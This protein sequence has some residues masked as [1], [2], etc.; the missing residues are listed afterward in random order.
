MTRIG[1]TRSR[2]SGKHYL[3]TINSSFEVHYIFGKFD[4]RGGLIIS[5]LDTG[6]SGPGFDPWDVDVLS[7]WT[8]HLASRNVF[9]QEYKW[10]PDK[11]PGVNCDRWTIILFRTSSNSSSHF[12]LQNPVT[13]E[14]G[15]YGVKWLQYP[16]GTESSGYRIQW[17][18]NQVATELNGSRI[19]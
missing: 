5:V 10:I 14:A 7:C 1:W 15:G 6:L 4:R 18:Q 2:E 3:S 16:V 13:T 17:L 9:T 8:R 12:L 11:V 19:L